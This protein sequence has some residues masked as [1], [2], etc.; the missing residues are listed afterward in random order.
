MAVVIDAALWSAGCR[1]RVT[2]LSCH[3]CRIT[4]VF[5]PSSETART[6]ASGKKGTFEVDD[7]RECDPVARPSASVGEE[8]VNL[9][10]AAGGVQVCEM[11]PTTYDT[12]VHCAFVDRLKL[13][14]INFKFADVS[15][16]VEGHSRCL[17][18]LNLCPRLP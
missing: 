11:V 6:H 8:V 17:G 13:G 14:S 1:F 10:H 3:H 12:V 18:V 9:R 4:V 15:Q 16:L 2:V 5:I 7:S